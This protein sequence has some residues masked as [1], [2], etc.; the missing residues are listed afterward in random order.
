M[1]DGTTNR[2]KRYCVYMLV[3]FL[4]TLFLAFLTE[5]FWA[6]RDAKV[7]FQIP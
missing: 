1:N 6:C 3:I 5:F 2:I 4:W 7:Y